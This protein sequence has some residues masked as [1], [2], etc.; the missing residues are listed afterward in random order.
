MKVTIQEGCKADAD[1][2]SEPSN[3]ALDD[4]TGKK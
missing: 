4:K 1:H 3:A 2:P